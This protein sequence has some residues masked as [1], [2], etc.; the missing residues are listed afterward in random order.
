MVHRLYLE[1]QPSPLALGR[2]P[3]SC[4]VLHDLALA[5][6]FHS[7]YFER[8]PCDSLLGKRD[9]NLKTKRIVL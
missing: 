4:R 9:V 3:G 7:L 6:V 5:T 8:L 1:K 2:N